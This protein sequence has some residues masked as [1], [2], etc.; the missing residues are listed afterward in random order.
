MILNNAY[1]ISLNFTL[2][3]K[4][5]YYRITFFTFT[6]CYCKPQFIFLNRNMQSSLA[7]CY[8][9]LYQAVIISTILI[10]TACNLVSPFA[11]TTETWPLLYS[12]TYTVHFYLR[13]LLKGKH[14]RLKLFH[15]LIYY[16]LYGTHA[17]L[18]LHSLRIYLT[19]N[20][21]VRA[22]I[23]IKKTAAY[24]Y[25]DTSCGNGC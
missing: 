18:V 10:I 5:G 16:S 1:C 20:Q 9:Y 2:H 23:L 12:Y 15:N 17:L 25:L 19:A 4:D 21:P 6:Y 7:H 13:L 3:F 14:K 24:Q 22:Y 11:Y 8:Y